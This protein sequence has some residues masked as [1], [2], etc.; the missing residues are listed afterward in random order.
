MQLQPVGADGA[1]GRIALFGAHRHGGPQLGQPVE[2]AVGCA[3]RG[4]QVER[5]IVPGDAQIQ[6]VAADLQQTLGVGEG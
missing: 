3:G 4:V 1:A 2:N 6:L 5:K